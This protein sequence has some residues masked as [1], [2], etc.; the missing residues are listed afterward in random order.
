MKALLQ[1]KKETSVLNF[2]DGHLTDKD[3]DL[4]I[5]KNRFLYE[6]KTKGFP[7]L[8]K[9]GCFKPKVNNKPK[10]YWGD[11]IKLGKSSHKLLL[12][13]FTF[14][15]TSE[16]LGSTEYTIRRA[17]KMAG[18]HEFSNKKKMFEINEALSLANDGL[19]TREIGERFNCT[20][21]AISEKLRRFGYKFNK[22][23]KKYEKC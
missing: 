16:K 1:N 12:E 9:F 10:K 21:Q 13:G 8:E 15:Q 11:M 18:L 2:L 6:C 17:L 3:F 4:M 23:T 20:R 5:Q 14:R 7:R 22:S 19:T